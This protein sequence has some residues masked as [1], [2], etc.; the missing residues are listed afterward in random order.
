MSALSGAAPDPPAEPEAA[1]RALASTIKARWRRGEPPD[2]SA[3]LAQ[4]HELSPFTS[5]VLDLAYEAYCQRREAG[6]ILDPE[7]YCGEFPAV[8]SSLRDLLQMHQHLEQNPHLLRE[9]ERWQTIPWPHEGETFLNFALR[10]ELGRGAFARVFLAA[11]TD[12]GGRLVALKVSLLGAG[13]AG[14]LGRLDHPN[15]VHVYSVQQDPATGLTAIC[16]AYEGRATLDD[17]RELAFAGPGRPGPAALIREAIA[18]AT[19]PEP[20]PAALAPDR[21]LRRGTYLDGILHLAAQLADALAYMHARGIQHGDL[22][23][24]NV[25][26]RPDGR[27]MLLDF[28]LAHDR[29]EAA[30]FRGGTLPYMAPE[31]LRHTILKEGPEPADLEDRADVFSLGVIL[32]ELLTGRGPF[33]PDPPGLPE[34]PLARLLL[35]RQQRGPRPLAEACPAADRSLCRLLQRCLALDPRQRP[36]AVTLA[37]QLR[38]ARSPWRRARRWAG[39][40]PFAVAAALLLA[41]AFGVG[42]TQLLSARD[43]PAVRSYRQG[44][45]EYEAGH[46]KEAVDHLTRAL[47]EDRTRA[48]VWFARGRAKL[49]LADGA[50]ELLA[51]AAYDFHMAD[52]QAPDGRAK[53]YRGYCLCRMGSQAAAAAVFEGALRDGHD[54]AVLRN[55]LAYVYFKIGK[56]EP[57]LD[58]L[59][60]AL[61]RDPELP[62]ALHNRALAVI[63]KVYRLREQVDQALRLRTPEGA[64]A[65]REFRDELVRTLKQGQADITGALRH[66]SPSGELYRDAARWSA[67][68]F[69]EGL[70]ATQADACLKHFTRAVGLGISPAQLDHDLCFAAVRLDPRFDAVRKLPRQR[71]RSAVLAE[72]LVNPLLERGG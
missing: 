65:A 12:L 47:E 17:V 37:G 1:A 48:E 36:S 72:R 24:S 33:G 51:E 67:L 70:D 49:K 10:R 39:R 21:A 63:P 69:Q 3:A 64:R 27:P 60:R 16:M 68:V 43:P 42:T 57:A 9:A 31:R 45:A 54:T 2:A 8:R 6:E 25:L 56:Y 62:A 59:D 20:V 5:L 40:H 61:A 18:V 32:Y 41:L 58:C 66:A 15:I 22:K 46:F 7:E 71:R 26:L 44:L 34:E 30:G 35:D 23:P 28:N 19:P 55:N 29:Q 4:H 14:T 38:R 53:G 11:Q 50:K 13:E 52:A